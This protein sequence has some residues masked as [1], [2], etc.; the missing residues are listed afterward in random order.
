MGHI[1]FDNVVKIKKNQVV[2]EVIEITNPM[3]TMCKHCQHGKKQKLNSRQKNTLGK[4][5]RRLYT[6]IYVG[7]Q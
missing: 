3:N 7:P 6:L 2:R 1:H 4:T 5:H